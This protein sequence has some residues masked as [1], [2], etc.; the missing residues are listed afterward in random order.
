MLMFSTKKEHLFYTI[1]DYEQW[2]KKAYKGWK[3]KYYKGLGTSTTSEAKEYF[4]LMKVVNYY[5]DTVDNILNQ[6]DSAAQEESNTKSISKES[7]SSE[8]D[9][10]N[11]TNDNHIDLAFRKNRSNDRKKW[12]YKYDRNIVTDFNLDKMSFNTFINTELI[13]FSNYDNYRS[14]PDIRDGFK[15]STR[16]IMYSSFKRNLSA[17]IKVAQLAGYVSENAAYHH[18]EASLEGAIIGLAYNFVGSNNINMLE[19]IGQFGTRLLGGKDSAQSRYIHTHLTSIAKIIFNQLDGPLYN[20]LD[21]DGSS[22]E[23]EAYCGILPMV[24]INGADGIGTGF[25]TKI[26]CYNPLHL[27]DCIKKKLNKQE[28][29]NIHPWYRGFIGDIIQINNNSYLTKG[30][31]KV[32]SKTEVNITELPI[33][34]WTEKYIDFLHKITIERGKTDAKHYIKSFQ[35]NSTESIVNIT[36]KFLPSTL[37]KFIWKPKKDNISYIEQKLKLTTKL[38][39]RNMWLF[40]THKCIH[41]YTSVNEII[42]EWYTYRHDLYIKRKEYILD[43]LKRELNIIK[44]KVQFIHEFID[45]TIEIRNKSK[46]TVINTLEEKQYPKLSVNIYSNQNINYDYILKMDLY[47]LTKEE[48]EH[49]IT[50]KDIKEASIALLENKTVKDIWIDELNEF[51]KKYKKDLKSYRTNTI[52]FK[53]LKN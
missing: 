50:Q 14:I 8:Q 30:K 46:Q 9:D 11:N 3:V 38:S 20:Y 40:N 52:T 6:L 42:D 43:K 32:L 34:T 44:Y 53:K 18:G 27:V 49:L 47:K 22:I 23:P 7:N 13:H 26:P 51:S 25:S 48:I 19:P 21:D 28:Y 1:Q 39:T 24:L 41:K 16:K 17:E 33:G 31:Y 5:K 15:P 29:N 36:V 35:D 37:E 4:K 2:K 10:L 12:L 45:G